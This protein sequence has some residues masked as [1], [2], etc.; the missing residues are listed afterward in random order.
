MNDRKQELTWVIRIAGRVARAALAVAIMLVLAVLATGSAQA[1][2]FTT[3]DAPGAGT[4]TR[5]GTY[6]YAIN[7]GGGIAGLY[8]DANNFSHGFV[9]NATPLIRK[10]GLAATVFVIASDGKLH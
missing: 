2:T 10:D 5:Q 3:F 1:Q 8:I 7:T 6:P 4:D 9:L